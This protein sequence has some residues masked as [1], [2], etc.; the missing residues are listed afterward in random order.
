[1][2]L[3]RGRCFVPFL[4]KHVGSPP[5]HWCYLDLERSVALE[6]VVHLGINF[7]KKKRRR[8]RRKE[9]ERKSFHSP[10]TSVY[11]SEKGASAADVGFSARACVRVPRSLRLPRS[12]PSAPSARSPAPAPQPLRSRPAA[13]LPRS[14]CLRP[15][16]RSTQAGWE[17]PPR[18]RRRVRRPPTLPH[19]RLTPPF[20]VFLKGSNLTRPLL[21]PVNPFQAARPQLRPDPSRARP[22]QPPRSPPRVGSRAAAGRAAWERRPVPGPLRPPCACP[23]SAPRRGPSTS[24]PHVPLREGRRASP[25]ELGVGAEPYS[26]RKTPSNAWR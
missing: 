11:P 5:Q 25:L 21:L 16:G 18:R 12:S 7:W 23:P 24:G 9:Q 20:P 14:T 4:R 1:M 26:S 17:P 10:W 6:P 2:C 13:P 19:Q 22:P 15:Q 8:G 3:G